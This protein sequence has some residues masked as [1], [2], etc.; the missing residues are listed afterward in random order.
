MAT[1]EE[2]T[3]RLEALRQARAWGVRSVRLADGRTVVYGT[4]VEL[5]AAIDDLTRQ[6]A[7]ATVAP[8]HTIR[9]YGTKGLET[10]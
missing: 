10:S 8:L 6:I 9:L 5:A 4:D 3:T 7:S 2:L 1:V